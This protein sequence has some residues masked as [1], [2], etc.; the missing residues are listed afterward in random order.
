MTD[1]KTFLDALY[2]AAVTSALP[3]H[4]LIPH[5]PA[6]PDHGRIIILAGGKAAGS[7]SLA[8]ERH[9]REVYKLGPDQLTGI[10][11]TRQGYG[12]PTELIRMIEA[13]HPVPNQAGLDG[14]QGV[15]ELA[16]QA[17]KDDLVLVLLSGGG[18]ANWI[19]P[20]G[21]LTLADKQAVTRAMLRSGAPI[22]AINTVR[23]RL[24]AIKGGRLAVLA[25]PAPLLTLEISDVPGDDPT[26]IASGPTVPD[27]TTRADTLSV[28]AQYHVTLPASAQKLLDDPANE[29]PRA[30]HPAFANA[31]FSLV[32]RPSDGVEAASRLVQEAGY[33]VLSLGA[34][35]EGEAREVAR[36]HADLALEAARAGRKLAILSGGELTVTMTGRGRGGPGQEYAL[37]LMIALG[38]HA[39]IA[40]V[41]GDTDGTD[42]GGGNPD[43]PAGAFVFPDSLARAKAKGLDPQAFLDNNDSTGFFEQLGDLLTPGPTG[44]NINDIR[45]ILIG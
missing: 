13:G 4:C 27:P 38:G 7:M 44:T 25:A 5:L 23:K 43:D 30:D 21:D 32:A 18:S 1:T 19:A 29:T 42:G 16:R 40:A 10:A 14:T 33:E 26:H 11:V 37:A 6:P 24:S 9:Y 15:M 12:E 3:S 36:H 20:A 39:G 31:R 34:D 45:V 8:A 2:H 28:L 22:D 17:T 35:L 41:A